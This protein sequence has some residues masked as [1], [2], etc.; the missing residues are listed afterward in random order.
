MGPVEKCLRDSGIKRHVARGFAC[1]WVHS[2]SKVQQSIQEFFNKEP[3]RS[4]NSDE[5]V[6][7]GAAVQAAILT[8]EGSSQ[9]QDLL[10]LDVTPVS[11]GLD[12]GHFVSCGQV[13]SSLCANSLSSTFVCVF[14]RRGCETTNMHS[15]VT[16][17]FC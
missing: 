1:R 17:S 6:A 9:V 4:I 10:L 2:I 7:Y 5:A 13:F 16:L 3:C 14:W 8:A 15:Y 12:Q 11:T